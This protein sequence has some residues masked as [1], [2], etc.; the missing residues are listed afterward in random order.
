MMLYQRFAQAV[1]RNAS[2]TALEI[3]GTRYSYGQIGDMAEALAARIH[4][5]PDAVPARIGLLANR[6]LLAYVGY[7]A[8]QRLGRSVVPLNPAFPEARTR[9]MV[10]DSGAGLV[11]ADLQATAPQVDGVR[12]LA[13][14]PTLVDVGTP[15]GSP[16]PLLDEPAAEAYLLFTSGSTGVPKGVP[17]RQSNVSAFLEATQDR[18]DMAPG[19][20][21]SQC[22]DL[23]FDLSVFD[24]FAVW[25]AGA[26]LVVPSRNDL[27][28]PVRFVAD[29]ALTHW[30][31][32]PSAISTAQA[33]GRLQPGTM[34][35]LRASLFCGEPLT[36]QQAS[37]WKEA[38]PA[39][40]LVNLYGPTEL[41]IS[42][43]DYVLPADPGE[44]PATSN[45]VLPIGTIYP[46][47]EYAVLDESGH[48]TPE[49]ELCVRGPQRFA[50]YLDPHG[51]R[52]RFHPEPAAADDR[53]VPRDHWYRTGDRVSVRGGLL[54]FLGRADQQVKINGYRVELGEIEAA[55]RSLGGVAD[56]VVV[57]VPDQAHVLGLYAVCLSHDS[58]PAHLRGELLRTLPA[59]MVPRRVLVVDQLPSNANDKV[60]RRAVAE[61]VR[62]ALALPPAES[63]RAA[64]NDRTSTG[65][66][67][68]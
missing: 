29:K 39:S 26:T 36:R 23:T 15:A 63:A 43:S 28:R 24:L 19:D 45:D 51:N 37:A 2:Q 21:C 25:S 9:A 57:A 22:F 32:V 30:F 10:V 17:I 27:L 48:D 31:S 1:A 14:D 60:D 67:S 11:L 61:L 5:Q 41:T 59:Y 16:P 4:G 62:T 3:D 33:S 6:S 18:Y 35:S 50:G 20:R 46:G 34:P 55:L 56:A 54:T 65:A 64:R 12:I 7:L 66:M 13:V 53:V 40:T 44:W 42:C 58:E 52:G 49:G 8:V 38:A 47:L 68:S